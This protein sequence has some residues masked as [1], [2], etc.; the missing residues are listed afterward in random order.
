MDETFTKNKPQQLT[1][2]YTYTRNSRKIKKQEDSQ[3]ILSYIDKIGVELL[4]QNFF[5]F[6]SFCTIVEK[7]KRINKFKC[8]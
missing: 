7:K 3:R 6:C 4:K 5:A 1:K 8:V 2:T